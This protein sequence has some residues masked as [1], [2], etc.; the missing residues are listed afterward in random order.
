MPA[1]M[2]P[3]GLSV[4]R[5]CALV[6]VSLEMEDGVKEEDRGLVPK[7][8]LTEPFSGSPLGALLLLPLLCA[9]HRSV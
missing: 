6:M 3:Q 1:L 5:T 8:L 4:S 9:P 7:T 2:R